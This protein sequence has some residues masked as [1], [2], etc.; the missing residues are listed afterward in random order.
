MQLL[1]ETISSKPFSRH[2]CLTELVDCAAAAAV[3]PAAAALLLEQAMQEC[4]RWEKVCNR[5]FAVLLKLPAVISMGADVIGRL[6]A[7]AMETEQPSA[8]TRLCMLP[9]AKELQPSTVQQLLQTAVDASTPSFNSSP[10]NGGYPTHALCVKQISSLLPAQLPLATLKAWLQQALQK[11]D[12]AMVAAL[13]C[14]FADLAEQLT[15]CEVLQYL[16]A[17]VTLQYLSNA[18]VEQLCKVASSSSSRHGSKASSWQ[19]EDAGSLLSTA[20]QQH[21]QHQDYRY[22]DA[23]FGGGF[24]QCAAASL[25]KLPIMQQL[26]G[27]AIAHLLTAAVEC[28][29]AA[30]VQDLCELPAA[31]AVPPF[32]LAELW[33]RCRAVQGWDGA[34]SSMRRLLQMLFEQL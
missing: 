28:D 29:V 27:E 25:M 7:V 21:V 20:V 5:S 26:P 8:I 17:A 34:A 18:A 6:L 12:G 2:D 22:I 15:S 31:T 10:E 3:P 14:G 19:I 11:Q 30:V 1:R 13:V 23:Y 24:Q 33:K 16:Q 32:E 9:A 4:P